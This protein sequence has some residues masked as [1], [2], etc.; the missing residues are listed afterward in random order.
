MIPT[1]WRSRV[2]PI[3]VEID[4]RRLSAVQ[5]EPVSDG[6]RLRAAASVLQHGS[7]E[8]FNA[9]SDSSAAWPT[10]D[11]ALRSV[12]MTDTDRG[13]GSWLS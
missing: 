3:G 4:G 12:T 10:K 6:F 7:S 5:L 1:P 9:S 8:P 13:R 2:T 11:S